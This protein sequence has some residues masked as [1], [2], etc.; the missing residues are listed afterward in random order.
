MQVL[1]GKISSFFGFYIFEGILTISL[2]YINNFF[3]YIT[4]TAL[5]VDRYPV[6]MTDG[7]DAVCVCGEEVPGFGAGGEDIVVA[8]PDEVGEFV[9]AQ[10]CPD[11]LHWVRLG[12]IGREME[13]GDVVG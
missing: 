9:G 13:Q 3:K 10:V 12:R 1:F 6:A 2:K 8:V 5:T 7:V 11:G 4:P